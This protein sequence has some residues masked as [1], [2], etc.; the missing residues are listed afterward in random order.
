M[1]AIAVTWDWVS[2]GSTTDPCIPTTS[3][4]T[5]RR[6]REHCAGFSVNG[7]GFAGY[8]LGTHRSD[9]NWLQQKGPWA[10]LAAVAAPAD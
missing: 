1:P 2:R 3:F 6:L 8:L 10:L 4:L 9:L 7:L 5:V